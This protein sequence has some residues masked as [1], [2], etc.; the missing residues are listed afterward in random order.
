RTLNSEQSKRSRGLTPLFPAQSLS[1]NSDV[2]KPSAVTT[3]M[4]VTT[5]RLVMALLLFLNIL[6]GVADG[7]DL[8][9]VFVGNC[10]LELVLELHDQFHDVERIGFQVVHKR[11]V[12]TDVF[13]GDLQLLADNPND[14]F[15]YRHAR[16]LQLTTMTGSPKG[17]FTGI[18]G[19]HISG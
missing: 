14:F 5:T 3:D 12:G 7:L 13:L 18:I 11:L 15:F 8:L 2:S 19:S 1:Q 17:Q 9:V 6:D 10:D 16:F 4:P